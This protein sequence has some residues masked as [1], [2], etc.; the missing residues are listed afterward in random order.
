MLTAGQVEQYMTHTLGSA[1]IGLSP[2]AL[3]NQAGR[4]L[5]SMKAWK[6][7]ERPEAKVDTRATINLT[8]AE[9]SEAGKAGPPPVGGISALGLYEASAFDNYTFLDGD[10]LDIT[11][12]TGATTGQYKVER[13]LDGDEIVLKSSIGS[14]A[15]TSTDITAKM[16]LDSCA[17]PSD[18]A[19]IVGY[20]ATESLINSIEFVSLQ[21]LLTLKTQ[22]IQVTRYNFFAAIVW[23]EMNINTTTGPTVSVPIL[24][25]WPAPSANEASTF[26][27][28]Y[29]AG[30]VDVD[31]SNDYIQIPEWME[32]LFIQLCITWVRGFK[33][34]DEA[35]LSRR[36][37]EIEQ[38]P[39]YAACIRRDGMIQPDYGPVRGGAVESMPQSKNH[40]LR[41]TVQGPA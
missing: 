29:R 12:G 40:F 38:S 41:S 35:S 3:I 22:E 20:D 26:S 11:G 24:K 37:V 14:A 36:L 1:Q 28:F 13:K 32:A 7:L 23:P 19:E 34:E 18:L 5:V 6:F 4:H 31:N 25:I 2:Y 10:Q 27:L 17:L 39:L 30:W 21:R 8:A 15:D 33:E 16:E 9:W